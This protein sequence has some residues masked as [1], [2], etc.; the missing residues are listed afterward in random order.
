[1]WQARVLVA[2]LLDR[3]SLNGGYE[4]LAWA[5]FTDPEVGRVGL[6]EAQARDRLARVHIGQVSMASS[7][8]GWIQGPGND[9][10]VKVVADADRGV[11]VGA[12]VVG[13]HAG[14]VMGLLALAVH[15][16]VPVRTLLTMHYAYPTLHR[17][18][19]DAVR[20]LA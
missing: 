3:E 7:T 12:T 13:P 20:A 16:A 5:T 6:S 4:G 17:A 15:A 19:G 9:G 10:F 18:I 11:L 1:M 8:R 2:D 14:E